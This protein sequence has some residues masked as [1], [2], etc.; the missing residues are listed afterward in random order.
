[1]KKTNIRRAIF[2]SISTKFWFLFLLFLSLSACSRRRTP[3]SYPPSSHKPP[4]VSLVG[5]SIQV[6]AFSQL[7]NAIRL[8]ERL[9]RTFPDAFYFRHPSGLYKVRFGT[10]SSRKDALKDGN[11][12]VKNGIIEE[13]YVVSPEDFPLV[14]PDILSHPDLRNAL[15]KTAFS[16]IGL[17]Y[18]WGGDSPE[19]GFDCS[20]LTMA[21]YELNGLRLPRHSSAQFNSGVS[22]ST[23]KLQKGDLVF[24]RTNRHGSVSHVGIYIGNDQFIHAPS[25]GKTIRRESM[26][27]SYFSKRFV[28]ART[29]LR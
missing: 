13:Y 23:S 4:S 16:F 7:N 14:R 2:L 5:Y 21:V 1:M 18:Q 6:G 26:Q 11:R 28:G 9:R 20:G 27:N 8:T 19:E 3:P 12:A 25:S 24:F 17:P 29:F 15:V 22:V 10:Y